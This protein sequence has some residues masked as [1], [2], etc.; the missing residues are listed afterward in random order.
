MN[1]HLR[2][3]RCGRSDGFSLVELLVALVICSLVS[4]ALGAMVPSSRAVFEHTPAAL[5]LQQRGRSAIDAIAKAVRSA[6]ITEVVPPILLSGPDLSGERFTQLLAIARTLHAAEGRLAADQQGWSGDLFLSDASCPDLED[7]C[8]FRQ[9]AS[10]V[11]AD[12]LGRFDL[13]T[14]AATDTGLNSI[15]SSV[16]FAAAYPAGSFVIEVDAYTFRL[17]PQPDGSTTLVR[18][19]VAGAVQPIVDDV[20]DLSFLVSDGHLDVSLTVHAADTGEPTRVRNRTFHASMFPR[21]VP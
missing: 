15:S 13:F 8:G 14:V 5:D 19:T 4:A 16:D 2:S 17:D 11:I 9:G 3:A 21:N 12:G 7:V 20:A 1:P 6:G 18:E 10:V